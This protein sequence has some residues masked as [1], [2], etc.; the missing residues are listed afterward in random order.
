MM[1]LNRAGSAMGNYDGQMT[2]TDFEK[3]IVK[4]SMVN[5]PPH[6]VIVPDRT[7]YHCFQTDKSSSSYAVM[8]DMI[9]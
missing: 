9:S 4:K 1:W 8:A 3:L 2:A 5:L 6:S 7:P